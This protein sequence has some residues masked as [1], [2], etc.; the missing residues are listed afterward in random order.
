MARVSSGFTAARWWPGRRCGRWS[1]VEAD[2]HGSGWALRLQGLEER[3]PVSRR[4]LSAVREA[5]GA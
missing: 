3:L 2:A 1:A 5:F 4:Q